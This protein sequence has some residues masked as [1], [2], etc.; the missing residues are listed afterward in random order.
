MSDDALYLYDAQTGQQV[1][2]AERTGL[3]VYFPAGIAG[4]T[5]VLD[6]REEPYTEN[7]I[8]KN[9]AFAQR[10]HKKFILIHQSQLD[11][12]TPPLEPA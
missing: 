3:D 10:V 7:S 4:W 1:G 8:A 11:E 2:T 5:D 9:C 12:E 6:C